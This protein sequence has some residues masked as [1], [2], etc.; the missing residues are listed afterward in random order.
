M[1]RCPLS[2]TTPLPLSPTPIITVPLTSFHHCFPPLPNL[3]HPCGAL[4]LHLQLLPQLHLLPHLFHL[5]RTL[6]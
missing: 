4:K 1:L 5:P 3:P 2:S 6:G